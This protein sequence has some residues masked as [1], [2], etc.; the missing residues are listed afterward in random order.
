V[1]LIAA[2]NMTFAIENVENSKLVS[3]TILRY[4]NLKSVA[5]EMRC[6]FSGTPQNCTDEIFL[7]LQNT[8]ATCFMSS[9]LGVG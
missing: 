1:L 9:L 5:L 4:S 3:Y 8:V 6:G 2:F 7:D